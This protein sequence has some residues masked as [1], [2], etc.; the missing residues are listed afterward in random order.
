MWQRCTNKKHKHWKHYG[1]RGIKVCKRW[2]SYTNFLK[3][4]GRK[5]SPRHSIER[6]KNDGNYQPSNCKWATTLEQSLN[7]RTS[8]KN[9]I[10][11]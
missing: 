11:A 3:D 8:I 4:M 10:R 5:P 2:K 7:K 9:R 1:G 6:I